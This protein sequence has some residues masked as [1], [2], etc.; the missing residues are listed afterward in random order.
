MIKK[1]SFK[2]LL[3]TGLA[4]VYFIP[5]V[6]VISW[7]VYSLTIHHN[8]LIYFS[9]ISFFEKIRNSIFLS[10]AVSTGSVIIGGFLTYLF[11]CFRSPWHRS[12]ML[13]LLLS[14]FAISPIIYL[15]ALTRLDCFNQLPV[16]WQS[17]Q[18]LS[19]NMSPLAAIIFIFSIGTLE[20][21][22]LKSGLMISKPSAVV[23]HIIFPQIK[24]SVITAF[25]IVFMLIFIH[26]EVPSFL[27]YRTY[28]EES[29]ARIV[30]MENYKEASLAS[31]PFLFLGIIALVVSGLMLRRFNMYHGHG[32]NLSLMKFHIN[33]PKTHIT[34][35]SI[36]LFIVVG[37][38]VFLL[39]K[40]LNFHSVDEL[41]ADNIS[42]IQNTFILSFVTAI[43]GTICGGF[44]YKRLRTGSH[45]KELVLWSGV[46]MFYWLTPS[47]LC[48]LALVHLSRLFHCDSI[49][50]D[51]LILCFGY[52]LR[53]LPIS[54]LL[55]AAMGT[56]TTTRQDIFLR[57]IKLSAYNQF[58]KIILPLHWHMWLIIYA[59]LSVFAMNEVSATVL[60][61]PPGVET[62]VVRI[63]NLMHYGDFSSVAFLSLVQVTLVFICVAMTQLMMKFY[64]K[65]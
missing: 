41:V 34:A 61:I 13:L 10:T 21:A 62:I 43:V 23:R 42:S 45:V 50:F 46:M 47:S 58:W 22:S 65:A 51:Y 33:T 12:G 28:A 35:G 56:I 53:L 29:L 55:F 7:I 19:L 40:E 38:L 17:V 59:V 54:F 27:G 32:N 30:A 4:I 63:Y 18:V 49:I 37:G 20:N 11:Y 57:F 2:D 15:V 64:D 6:N 60:L 1:F 48:M 39:L 44:L 26:E 8:F 24:F 16:F 25:L 14:F 36:L 5:L 52:L 3:F 31:L 9:S